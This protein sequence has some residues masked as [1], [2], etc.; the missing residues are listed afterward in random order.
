MLVYLL[1]LLTWGVHLDAW[2][3]KLG[4]KQGEVGIAVIYNSSHASLSSCSAMSPTIHS[5]SACK[6]LDVSYILSCLRS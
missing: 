5:S 1:Y 4:I 3:T 2:R 6:R